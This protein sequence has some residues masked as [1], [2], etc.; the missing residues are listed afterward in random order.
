MQY[1]FMSCI[2]RYIYKEFTAASKFI[3]QNLDQA[4]IYIFNYKYVA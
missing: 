1:V 2:D 3:Q 4:T